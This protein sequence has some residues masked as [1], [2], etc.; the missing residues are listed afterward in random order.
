[1]NIWKKLFGGS[2]P[3]SSREAKPTSVQTTQHS[4]PRSQLSPSISKPVTQTS[5]PAQQ[6][7]PRSSDQEKANYLNL[8]QQEF[9]GLPMPALA[10]IAIRSA[11]RV[12]SV[13]A[14]SSIANSQE[15]LDVISGRMGA[16]KSF[17]FSHEHPSLDCSRHPSVG[18][19]LGHNLQ[20]LGI[21]LAQIYVSQSPPDRSDLL[22]GVANCVAYSLLIL[23]K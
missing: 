18:G 1:M 4:A 19:H 3:Q 23:D 10:A 21:R 8:L 17:G 11:R 15:L 7:R 13:F 22:S 6:T 14:T 16:E 12:E 20:G 9:S 2:K 5:K